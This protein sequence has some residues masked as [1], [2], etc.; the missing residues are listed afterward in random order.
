MRHG[1]SVR[2]V[3]G[4]R[5]MEDAKVINNPSRRCARGPQGVTLPENDFRCYGGG[6]VN[7]PPLR[8][9]GVILVIAFFSKYPIALNDDI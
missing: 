1:S 2:R 9:N 6:G 7:H 3:Q 4:L 8:P 5:E